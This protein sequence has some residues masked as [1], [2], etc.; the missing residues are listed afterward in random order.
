MSEEKLVIGVY[1]RNATNE[2]AYF[3]ID[4]HNLTI[5]FSTDGRIG[6]AIGRT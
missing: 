4:E 2:I 6:D 5:T 3:T 1:D